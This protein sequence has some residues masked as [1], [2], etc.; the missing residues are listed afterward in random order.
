M[1]QQPSAD[2]LP[3]RKGEQIEVQRPAEDRIDHATR[4]ARRIPIKRQRRPLRHHAGASQSGDNQR[5]AGPDEAQDGIDRQGYRLSA[6]QNR[7]AARQAGEGTPASE[8][9]TIRTE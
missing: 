6:D 4:G 7:V 9:E 3:R 1:R 8:P 5:G 2:E